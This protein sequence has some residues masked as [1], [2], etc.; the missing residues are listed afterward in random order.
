M[1]PKTDDLVSRAVNLSIGVV[2][3]GLGT[4]FGINILST[5]S[6]IDR[7]VEQFIKLVKPIIG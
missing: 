7:K 6:E 5:D 4:D 2:D 1:L 3:S